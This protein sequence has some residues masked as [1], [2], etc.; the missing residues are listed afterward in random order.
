MRLLRS[1]L[2]YTVANLAT[3]GLPFLLLPFLTRALGPAEYGQVVAFALIVGLTGA[4][5]GFN[6]HAAVGVMWFRRDAED[7]R[8]LVGMAMILALASTAVI[9]PATALVLYLRPEIGAGLHP[10]WGAVAAV[11]AGANVVVQARLGLWQ[12]RDM[13]WRVGGFQFTTA[14]LNIS[15]SLFAVLVLGFGAAGRNG[16]YAAAT[17]AAALIAVIAL[18]RGGELSRHIRR[19]DLVDLVRFGCPLAVHILAGAILATADRWL[20][21]IRLDAQALGLYGAGAQ[22]GMVMAILGDAFV[23][24]YAPWLY[25]RL[26]GDT[27]EDRLWAVGAAYGVIPLFLVTGLALGI[28]LHFA[29]GMV[30]GPAFA[31]SAVVLPWFMLGGALNGVYLSIS[32]LYFFSG[33][34][35][36]L[37]AV[38]IT[39]G[40]I[41]L[42]LTIV[43][44]LAFGM[45]GAA[46]GYAAAQGV[47]G[48][49]AMTVAMKTFDLPWGQPL[50][51]LKLMISRTASAL[52]NQFRARS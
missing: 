41:S 29:A 20:V 25:G 49:T 5:A 17:L 6:V 33:R 7:M 19:Q 22:L 26:R 27:A 2:I 50:A 23:K 16:A 13:P 46:M 9:A 8:R 3:A 4:L 1:G 15:A 30:L 21:A 40:I 11:T 38:T 48:L 28:F 10:V 51:A 52:P 34:T 12:A 24:A 32:S 44:T 43:L 47:L 18:M 36:L 31:A 45:I 37:A 39:S 14:A 35:A 42:L